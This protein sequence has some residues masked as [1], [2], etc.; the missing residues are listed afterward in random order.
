M[1]DYLSA[2]GATEQ[3]ENVMVGDQWQACLRKATPRDRS[4]RGRHHGGI[5]R[6]S[7]C[8]GS[9]R[10]QLHRKTLRGGG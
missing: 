4:L 1:K 5:F 6:R 10:L 9:C 2:L 7:H 3:D 8:A